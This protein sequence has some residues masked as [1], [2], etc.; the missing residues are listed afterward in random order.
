MNSFPILKTFSTF[1]QEVLLAFYKVKHIKC[2]TKLCPCEIMQQPLWVN[3]H[4]KIGDTYLYLKA[5]IGNGILYVVDLINEN[6]NI[7]CD[8]EMYNLPDVKHDIY[9]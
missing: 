4:F 8:E 7:M 9:T 3:E 6:G 2:F 5:W 1:Y